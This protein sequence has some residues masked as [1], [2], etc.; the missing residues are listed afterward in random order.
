MFTSNEEMTVNPEAADAAVKFF[1]YSLKPNKVKLL[2]TPEHIKEESKAIN[3]VFKNN[4]I[5]GMLLNFTLS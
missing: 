4:Q 1:Q 5:P 2:Y 3:E